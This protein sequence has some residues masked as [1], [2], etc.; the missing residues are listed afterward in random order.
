MLDP[1]LSAAWYL[2]GFQR[3][4][5][6][7][8]DDAIDRFARAMRLSPLDP[9]M[10]RMQTGTAMAH[11]LAG[12]FDSA[13]VWAEKAYGD[14][15]SFLLAAAI[16]AASHALA[17]RVDQARQALHRVSRLDPTLRA[18]TLDEWVLLHRREDLEM[19]REGL[20]KAGLP[21]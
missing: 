10:V 17:G 9:E 20:R 1:N 4:T 6:G 21:A 15:P 14:L 5:R 8:H 19:F 7:E 2:S 12:R 13:L 18:S 16:V 11:L 3:I